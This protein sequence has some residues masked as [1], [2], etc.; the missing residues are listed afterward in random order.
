MQQR[1]GTYITKKVSGESFKAYIPAKLPPQP[2]IEL[3]K[4][5]GLLEKAALAIA[6]L[7]SITK[8]IP[9][10]ALFT[11][12]YVRKEALLSNQIEG[13]QSSF[14]DLILFEHDQ[15]PEVSLDDVE[16]VS[17]YVK[18]LNYGLK[19]LRGGFPMSMRLLREI[20]TVL[21]SGGRGSSKLPGELR[22]S[23]NWI[24]GT[25]PGNA[26]FVPPPVENL[27][28]CLAD[29]EKF[30]HNDTLPVLI[31]AGIAHVQFETIHPFLDGNGRLGRL[32]ITLLLVDGGIIDAPILYLSLYLK[33]N[34]STYYDLL[35]EVRT[36][37][38][39][40]TWLEFFLNGILSSSKQAIK[41]TEDINNIFAEDFV[42]INTLGRARFS[43]AQTLE[44]LKQLP[45]ISVQVL[46][47]ALE[48]SL[49]T[50]RSSLNHL[51]D[52]GVIEEV[53]G[54]KRGKI[55]VYRKYLNILEKGAEP[56]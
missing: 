7:N 41:T 1:L 26:L 11:Y 5:S 30:L 50:A 19:R 16:E 36:N 32:L 13:T 2:A 23:Q 34:R 45:Q 55:Y 54:N 29:L 15:K 6:Q 46:A 35:Q 4:L 27:A 53:S 14:A 38:T 44:Y 40:E 25:R 17:N 48:I 39:W 49:P 52:L 20:H 28:D 21:L 51:V 22:R 9:N 12:M 56:L 47:A 37:G 18:A 3:E 8:S 43:C 24:G 10:T 33:Q 31:K 42:K